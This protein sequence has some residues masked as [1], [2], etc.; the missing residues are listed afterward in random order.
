MTREDGYYLC[1]NTEGELISG[2]DGAVCLS[3]VANDECLW[4]MVGQRLHCAVGDLSLALTA[5]NLEQKTCEVSEV[6]GALVL[7]QGPSRLPSELLAELQSQ[8]FTILDNVMDAEAV[9]QFKERAA[10]TR[11]SNHADETPGDGFFWMMDGL[12]WSPE[13]CRAVTHPVALWMMQ[14]YLSTEDIHTCHQPVIT[15]AKPADSLLGTYPEG[16]W[17]SDYPY[18][19]GVFPN[20]YWPETTHFG[21]QFNICINAFEADNAATQF[22]PGSHILGK[23]PSNEFNEGGTRM[24][25]GIHQDVRQ[26]IAPAGAALIYDSRTWHRACYELNVCGKDRIAILNAVTPA[27]V[28]PMIDKEPVKQLYVDSDIPDALTERERRDIKRLF[29]SSLLPT[30]EGMPQLSDRAAKRIEPLARMGK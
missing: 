26:Y 7:Q 12:S 6:S 3:S 19:P 25:E 27:W 16:G 8:G 1:R 10:A 2:R 21:V 11:A 5:L 15:T 13:L 9:A 28:R 22:V 18:H 14:Q 20:D 29:N 4:R 24:G 17:H 23:G 30:P